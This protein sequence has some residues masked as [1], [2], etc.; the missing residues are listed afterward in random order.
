M[1]IKPKPFTKQYLDYYE[2][3]AWIN[4]RLG[5]SINDTQ[6]KFML[7]SYGTAIKHDQTKEYRNW[8]HFLVENREVSNGCSIYIDS[9]LLIS[10]NEWQN[11]ITK[12]FIKE[13]G[14]KIEY[15]VSW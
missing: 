5:Y 10:G 1:R 9:D 14:E 8:W 15:Y 3:E 12:T 4:A 2:C 13:F 7:D 6:G 11:E